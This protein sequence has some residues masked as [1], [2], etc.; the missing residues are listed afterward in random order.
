MAYPYFFV[1]GV[2]RIANTWS[3][4]IHDVNIY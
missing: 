4:T 2:I 3:L 1:V